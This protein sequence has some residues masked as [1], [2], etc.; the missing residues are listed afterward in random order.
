MK[1]D[2]FHLG[3]IDPQVSLRFVGVVCARCRETSADDVE[4]S[5]TQNLLE[6]EMSLF[7]G[8]KGRG[9]IC[10]GEKS[11]ELQEGGLLLVPTHMLTAA[12]PNAE[13]W[14]FYQFRFLP[15]RPLN[16]FQE[17]TIY[18]IPVKK[19]EE[20]LVKELFYQQYAGAA[21]AGQLI[22]AL[23]TGQ[24]YRWAME[25]DTAGRSENMYLQKIQ[26]AI[27]YINLHLNEPVSISDLSARF[28][29][30][31]RHFRQLFRQATGRSPKTYQGELRL[32][33]CA[34]LLNTTDLSIQD[35]ADSLGYYSQYQLS[36]DFKKI[37]GVSPSDYR[38][39]NFV[40][41]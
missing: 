27:E 31:E 40:S 41:S 33:K 39:G 18:H 2:S 21:Y 25:L 28:S 22:S 5:M 15:D 17:K 30:S 34:H 26:F 37:F 1:Q 10:T 38:K 9:F 6:G 3:T 8:T 7:R 14:Q 4:H 24:L 32:N 12:V 11:A 29:I 19:D 16:L 35:I 20:L 36:R 23:F 13:E